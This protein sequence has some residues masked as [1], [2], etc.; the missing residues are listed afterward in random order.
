MADMGMTP[1]LN[2]EEE[3]LQGNLD[4][5]ESKADELLNYQAEQ[6]EALKSL[7]DMIAESQ[8]KTANDPILIEHGGNND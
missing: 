4:S 1:K 8:K 2:V 3:P 5:S 7:R 6:T